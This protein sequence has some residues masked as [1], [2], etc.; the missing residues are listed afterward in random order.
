MYAHSLPSPPPSTRLSAS[1]PDDEALV[2]TAKY[3]GYEFLDRI[4]NTLTLR[5]VEAGE[6]QT[7]EILRILPFTSS[8]KRMSVIVRDR[9]ADKGQIRIITKGADA[10]MIGRIAE[11]VAGSGEFVSVCFEYI[12]VRMNYLSIR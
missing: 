2:Y 9:S 10:T 5:D 6:T 4:G 3:F 7:V 8:R 11:R 1:N 12:V